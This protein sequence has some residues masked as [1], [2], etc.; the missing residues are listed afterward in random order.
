MN[1]RIGQRV[2]IHWYPEG[3]NGWHGQVAEVVD[4]VNQG[5]FWVRPLSGKFKGQTGSFFR[6]NLIKLNSLFDVEDA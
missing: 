5:P 4:S 1:L 6:R 3:P 2:R